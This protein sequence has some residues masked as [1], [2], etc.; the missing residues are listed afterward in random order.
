MSWHEYETI[1]AER[2]QEE[3][4]WNMEQEQKRLY[5]EQ[6]QKRLYKKLIDLE[7]RYNNSIESQQNDEERILKSIE[8]TLRDKNISS[9]TCKKIKDLLKN[10]MEDQKEEIIEFD[11]NWIC[12]PPIKKHQPDFIEEGEMN[13]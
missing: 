9:A 3:S 7:R 1:Q 11:E 5:T 4:R 2:W 12:K 10:H 13:I 6:E 8:K